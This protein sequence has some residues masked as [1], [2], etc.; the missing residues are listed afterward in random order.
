MAILRS[1]HKAA[2]AKSQSKSQPKSFKELVSRIGQ[3]SQLVAPKYADSTKLVTNFVWGRWT[4]YVTITFIAFSFLL[5]RR[6]TILGSVR[7]ST[8]KQI[9]SRVLIPSKFAGSM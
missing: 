9:I 8:T 7:K 3:R 1:S 2:E 5:E 6:L 4:Q